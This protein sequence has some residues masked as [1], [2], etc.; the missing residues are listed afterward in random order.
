MLG[1]EAFNVCSCCFLLR[2]FQSGRFLARQFLPGGCL[3]RILEAFGLKSLAFQ[4]CGFPLRSLLPASFFARCIFGGR[5]WLDWRGRHGEL[6]FL[7]VLHGDYGW[8][9]L[10]R[11]W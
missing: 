8:K 6:G 1:G 2:G 10:G 9:W 4:S 7:G 3:S 11:G 5:G